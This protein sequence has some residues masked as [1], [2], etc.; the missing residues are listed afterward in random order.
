M[1]NWCY[2][3]VQVKGAPEDLKKMV[4]EIHGNNQ[5]ISFAKVLPPPK[6]IYKSKEI[7]GSGKMPDWYEWCCEKWGTKWDV[8]SPVNNDVGVEVLAS[9]LNYLFHTAWSPALPVF[10]EIAKRHPRLDFDYIYSDESMD[11][12]GRARWEGGKF[13]FHNQ[14]SSSDPEFDCVLG[15][16]RLDQKG[17]RD[18]AW[19]QEIPVAE[20]FA[21]LA[22]DD[23]FPLVDIHPGGAKNVPKKKLSRSDKIKN[24]HRQI[25][26]TLLLRGIIENE[27]VSVA[28]RLGFPLSTWEDA[29]IRLTEGDGAL[30]DLP[31]AAKTAHESEAPRVLAPSEIYIRPKKKE[32]EKKGESSTEEAER[33]VILKSSL[34]KRG[35][36]SKPNHQVGG[37]RLFTHGVEILSPNGWSVQGLVKDGESGFIIVRYCGHFQNPPWES[38][39]CTEWRVAKDTG[40]AY[41]SGEA[42][43]SDGRLWDPSREQAAVREWYPDG[44]VKREAR[45]FNNKN[46]AK[47]G[48]PSMILYDTDG[49]VVKIE[50]NTISKDS[51]KQGIAKKA[52]I[53]RAERVEGRTR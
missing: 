43:C 29:G 16:H 8:D 47:D 1:P 30:W 4:R 17:V 27:V 21:E 7:T 44:K 15:G 14:L 51:S 3:S 11:M 45:Y 49:S 33:R 18:T 9:E 24:I 25:D 41:R 12:G 5:A 20:G 31:K 42:F 22:E 13:K 26:H 6:G 32:A 48:E 10:D 2:N 50:R 37:I 35:I 52:E 23:D 40:R 53:S 38:P 46:V 19:V 36:N 39:S 28:K 34:S